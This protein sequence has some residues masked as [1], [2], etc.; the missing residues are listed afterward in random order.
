MAEIAPNEPS[1]YFSRA[2]C[3]LAMGKSKSALNDF[4]KVLELKPESLEAKLYRGDLLIKLGD[5]DQAHIDFENILRNNPQNKNA[6]SQLI[7]VQNLKEDYEHIIWLIEGNKNCRDAIPMLANLIKSSPMNVKLHE[8]KAECLLNLGQITEAIAEY[9]S[10]SNLIPDDTEFIMKASRALFD[11]GFIEDAL[12]EIRKCLK[13]DPESKACF[14]FYQWVKKLN[15]FLIQATSNVE[16]LQFK[17]C[18]HNLDKLKQSIGDSPDLLRAMAHRISQKECLCMAKDNQP[19]ALEKC[20]D[21]L[22]MEPNDVETLLIR[23]HIYLDNDE[24]NKAKTDF[25]RVK[26]I[27]PN[28]QRAHEGLNK[29]KNVNKRKE[30][31]DYYSILGVKKSASTKEIS[32]AYRILARKWH[33]DLNKDKPKT[34]EKKFQDIG[35]AKE[36]LTNSEKRKLY[37]SGIDPNRPESQ[38]QGGTP[39]FFQNGG[40]DF[41]QTF[42][43]F[44]FQGQGFQFRFDFG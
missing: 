28:E 15:R 20:E 1:T 6:N 11:M 24:N 42:D 25:E 32:K 39:F 40:G 41:F 2:T 22:H 36:V 19:A 33:P 17:E 16:A 18:L 12:I 29:I 43:G 10:I 31:K 9:K 30:L 35:E 4:N 23:A 27:D 3:F 8:I 38:Q 37:D 13:V 7:L 34:A 5:Y 44:P 26:E 14:P 21:A